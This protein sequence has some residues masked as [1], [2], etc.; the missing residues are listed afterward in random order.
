MLPWIRKVN[1][2]GYFCFIK[3]FQA[4]QRAKLKMY[5]FTELQNLKV[6][7]HYVFVS[8]GFEE[9]FFFSVWCEDVFTSSNFRPQIN[10][11]MAPVL[12]HLRAASLTLCTRD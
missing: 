1:F 8:E 11:N 6:K 5:S 4:A 9:S 7:C 10:L 12:I 3:Y 2:F